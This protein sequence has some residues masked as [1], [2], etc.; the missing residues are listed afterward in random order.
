MVKW[1]ASNKVATADQCC[2]MCREFKPAGKDDK[3]CNVWVYCPDEKA[4]GS[5]Y[6]ECWLKHLPHPEGT[7]PRAQGPHVPWMAGM[8][9][10]EDKEDKTASTTATGPEGLK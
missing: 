2:Q 1:G 10:L 6:Q 9:D 3:Q 4:C 5:Q 8:R 7:K